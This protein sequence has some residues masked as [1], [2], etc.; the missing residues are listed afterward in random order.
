MKIAVLG[1]GFQGACVA[2]ELAARGL[3]VDLYDEN[4]S[5]ITQAGVVNEGK[6]HLGLTYAN[7]PTLRTAE[8]MINGALH[9]MKNINRWIEMDE[10]SVSLSQPFYYGICNDTIVS[11]DVINSYFHEVEY[12]YREMKESLKLNYLCDESSVVF[13]KLNDKETDNIFFRNKILSAYKTIEKAVDVQKLA[14][15]L[16]A[17]ILGSKNINFIC[18]ARVGKVENERNRLK[19]YYHKDKHDYVNLYDRVVNSLWHNRLKIDASLGIVP[20]NDWLYRYKVGIRFKCIDYIS[21]L[22]SVTLALGPFGDIVNYGDQKFYI[23]WYPS[24][25]TD[26]SKEIQPP[27]WNGI[28]T[29][30]KQ[31]SVMQKREI[32]YNS[33]EALSSI[34]PGMQKIKR[35]QIIDINIRGGIIF[36][37]GKTDIDDIDSELHK[38]YEV[39]VHSYRNYHSIDTGKY[40]L[41]PLFAV[42]VGNRILGQ[43]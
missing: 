11:E 33:L 40:S 1:G 19:V 37:W 7:D 10:S 13:K 15:I 17:R 5:I 29:P 39:G 42:E 22:P 24:G 26:S 2:L 31:L 18:Q 36:S 9:F 35:D 43:S 6:I 4:N 8:L 30:D 34:I 32:F 14:S 38:R 16:R 12:I 25:M 27:D 23:S 21:N 28:Y 3:E 41:A 20:N